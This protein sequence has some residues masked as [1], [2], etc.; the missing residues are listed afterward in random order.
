MKTDLRNATL[1]L[2]LAGPALAQ[3]PLD[4]ER[5]LL[6]LERV[7][8]ENA[9]L[10]QEL[11][12]LRN[13]VR[14]LQPI[15][16]SSPR[17]A[18][19]E[20]RLDIQERR[21]SEQAQIKLESSHRFPIR[22]TGMALA[23]VFLNGPHANG[24][25]TPVVA[26][27]EPGRGTGGLTLRQS[28]LGL[29]YSGPATILGGQ[30]RGSIFMD[31]FDGLSQTSFGPM[32]MRTASIELDWKTRGI[33]F[34]QEK[35]LIAVR[36]PS[37]FSYS[38]ISPLTGSGNLWRWQ[39][40]IRFEQRFSLAEQTLFRAQAA[41]YQTS[42]ESSYAAV[43]LPEL[44]RRRPA[45]QGRFGLEHR[46]GA[47]RSVEFAAGF[48][49]S[50]THIEGQT[51]PSR[52]FMIDWGFQPWRKIQFA[53]T[54]FRG[55]NIH[56]FGALR[57]GFVYVGNE[58][59]RPVESTGGWG[60]ISIPVHSRLTWNVFGGIHDDRDKDLLP[61]VVGANLTGAT[62]LQY[63]VAPNT[64]VGIEALQIRSTYIGSGTRLNNRY[65]LFV[66]YLF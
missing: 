48:H 17:T 12:A 40:Q 38:G 19:L 57:Q 5:L 34:M 58:V 11:T 36:D 61:G 29:E 21:V 6:R 3:A 59:Y 52:L 31:F 49:T 7:E 51:L 43:A 46:W 47:D 24:L 53:G 39:P 8:K 41:F 44:E 15:S 32:R 56:H 54:F 30:V 10:Q 66:A 55:K 1:L 26:S 37:T 22:V 28:V 4:L 9:K 23:N 65:D 16:D 33:A 42:E 18:D 14:K 20:E 2:A 60:Q 64:I 13:E 27:R 50:Q 45:L 62:N 63:R 35:P 25:D